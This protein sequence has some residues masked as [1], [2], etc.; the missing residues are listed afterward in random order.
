MEVHL[1][2]P[3]AST[4]I[5]SCISQTPHSGLRFGPWLHAYLLHP[6]KLRQVEHYRYKAVLHL[7]S[8]NLSL[9]KKRESALPDGGNNFSKIV[10]AS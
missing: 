7:G 9:A 1:L 2:M 3:E 4:L 10:I 8:G 6:N 5:V